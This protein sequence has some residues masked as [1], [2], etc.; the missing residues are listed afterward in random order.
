MANK[1]V[2]VEEERYLIAV[3][4]RTRETLFQAPFI[5]GVSSAK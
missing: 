1:K 3:R 4:R 2:R 5:H